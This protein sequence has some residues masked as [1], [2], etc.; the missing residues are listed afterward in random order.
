MPP[1]GAA[2]VDFGVVD[3]EAVRAIELSNDELFVRILALGATIQTLRTP[4]RSGVTS[5]IVLG[6]STAREYA[7]G[8]DYFGATV[9]R[10]ANRIAHGRFSLDG[11][12][13]LLETN[14]GAHHLHGGARGLDKELWTIESLTRVPVLQAIL[15]HRSPHG[16]GGYP[17]EL[18]V[19]ATYTLSD[20]NELAIEYRARTDRPTVVNITSHSYFNLAGERGR[21]SL[22]QLLTIHADSYTPVDATLIPTGE[23]RSVQGSPF[24]FRKPAVIGAAVRDGSDEQIRLARGYDH[25]FILRGD[26]GLLRP[27]ARLEDPGSGRVMELLSTAPGLQFYSGNQLDGSQLGKE[28]RLYRQGDGICLEPQHFPDAPNRPAFLSARL[29]P[30]EEYRNGMALRFFS[31]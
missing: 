31:M 9:G 19:Q 23:R 30:G 29:N 25:N 20:E 2:C 14:D 11:T 21:D 3:G 27:A 8:C 7:E 6:Y 13:Y 28:G 12:P 18:S 16:H 26:P 1:A 10:Y 5:D 15:T 24:D 22:Q 17:G 4:D